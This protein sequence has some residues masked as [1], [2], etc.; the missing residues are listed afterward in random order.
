VQFKLELG[1]NYTN[2]KFIGTYETP[3]AIKYA[4]DAPR[5]PFKRGSLIVSFLV[6]ACIDKSNHA[7]YITKWEGHLVRGNDD[8]FHARSCAIVTDKWF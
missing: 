1:L 3:R 4:F 8:V 7:H 2:T 5:P 6:A